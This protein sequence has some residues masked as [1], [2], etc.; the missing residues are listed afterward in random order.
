MRVQVPALLTDELLATASTLA[1][2]AMLNLVICVLWVRAVMRR[3][4]TGRL[5]QFAALSRRMNESGLAGE[6]WP[7]SGDDDIDRLARAL[8]HLVDDL[9]RHRAALDR[10]AYEDSVTGIASR[11]R[12]LERMAERV[13][14]P[15]SPSALVYIDLV[16]FKP[17]NDALGH[18][19]GDAVLRRLAERM[20]A[21]PAPVACAARIGGDEFGLL[22]DGMG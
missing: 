16:G 19:A 9:D 10:L 3:K 22:L 2:M 20:A 5:G 13:A 21:L 14:G 4:V 11:R 6:R 15:P 18:A 12:L 17:I 1:I 7:V 8:N